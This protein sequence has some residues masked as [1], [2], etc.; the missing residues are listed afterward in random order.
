MIAKTRHLV[1]V[2]LFV[3]F[4]VLRGAQLAAQTPSTTTTASTATSNGSVSVTIL[5]QVVA[6]MGCTVAFS[7]SGTVPVINVS[8]C[9]AA[10]PPPPPTTPPPTTPPPTPTPVPFALGATV[11]TVQKANVWNAVTSTNGVTTLAGT[12]PNSVAGTVQA[13][14][15][16]SSGTVFWDIQFAS[17]ASGWVGQDAMTVTAAAPNPPPTSTGTGTTTPPPTPDPT[18]TPDPDPSKKPSNIAA[19]PGAQ[20]GGAASIGGR[21]GVVIEVTNLNDS[22]GGSLRACIEASGPRTCVFR[23]AGR[24][25]NSKRLQIGNPYITIAGQT[26]PGNIVLASAAKAQCGGDCTTLFVSTHD[27][28]VRYLTYDGSAAT[29]TGPDTGTVC[30]EMGSGNV[31]NVVWDHVTARWWGNKPFVTTANNVMQAVQNLTVQWSLL[32]E[33]NTAHPVVVELDATSGS[34]LSSINQ[35]FHH[36]FAA[37][38]QHRWPLTNIHS[39]RWVNNL[40]YNNLQNTSDFSSLAWGGLHG[41]YI[42][43]KYVDGPQSVIKVHTYLF[44]TEQDGVDSSDNCVNNNPCDNP[45]PPSIYMVNNIG[46]V[47]NQTGG[48]TEGNTHEVN[49]ATQTDQT[50]QGWEG[51]EQPKDGITIAPVPASWFRSTPLPAEPYPIVADPAENLDAVLLPTVGN[52]RRL[53]CDGTWSSSRDSQDARVIAQ[54]QAV[55]AGTMFKGQFAAPEITSATPCVESLHDGIPDQWKQ[56]Q[57]LSTSDKNLYKKLAPTG[58][59][60]LETYL[61]GN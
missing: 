2:F 51:G 41:D 22:G 33:P 10:T 34:S 11:E 16:A 60:W 20:G 19:F 39:M 5:F 7:S 52:S 32:Y 49:D 23:V 17:G 18:P 12:Q 30:C 24:I 53:G 42:G 47:G 54:Y 28:I 55:G 40:S 3:I 37:N 1:P 13:G 58:Y 29:P 59:T 4:V 56:A 36:N 38:Y 45:G 21:G 14:P 15:V 8:G 35:D 48:P 27:V 43:N 31:Y 57:K 50:Y 26:A 44:N 6:P 61:N 9:S 46:H 25:T